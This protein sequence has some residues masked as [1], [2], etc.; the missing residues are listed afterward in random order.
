[1]KFIIA[2]IIVALLIVIL[3]WSIVNFNKITTFITLPLTYSKLYRRWYYYRLI[4][5]VNRLETYSQIAYLCYSFEKNYLG[6]FKKFPEVIKLKQMYLVLPKALNQY[7]NLTCCHAW[8]NS[9]AD[10]IL[11]L[12]SCIKELNKSST[13][14]E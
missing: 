12:E 11:F 8:F 1:M 3:Y 14:E 10:R 4:K 13:D 7:G 5:Y 6:N 2:L 9:N